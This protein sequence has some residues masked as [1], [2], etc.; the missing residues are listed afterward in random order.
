MAVVY[1]QNKD[2][3]E[4]AGY[5]PF[6]C[7]VKWAPEEEATFLARFSQSYDTPEGHGVKGVHTW[8]LI[9]KNTMIVIG[10]MNSAVSLQKFCTSITHGTG[11]T[12]E[13]G[14]ATDHIGLKK[15]LEG[16]KP[17][18]SKIPVPKG[19][20]PKGAARKAKG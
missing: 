11:I 8:N 20:P 3:Y 7:I 15:A 6:V 5:T 4:G 9:G 14:P 2:D 10:W 16:L 1:N 19:S 12:M 17:R 13:A 18:F